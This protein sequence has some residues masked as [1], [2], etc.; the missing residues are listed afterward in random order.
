MEQ[1]LP[2]YGPSEPFRLAGLS[3]VTAACT[4]PHSAAPDCP[5]LDHL[6]PTV[7][8]LCYLC[9]FLVL[10]F[11]HSGRLAPS[12]LGLQY[13]MAIG[14]YSAVPPP[15]EIAQAQPLAAP[16]TTTTTAAATATAQDDSAPS[17]PHHGHTASGTIDIE[18][19]TLSALQSLSVSP[20]AT[21]TG[22][23]PLS[24]PL[25]EHS[26]L[27]QHST[28]RVTIALNEGDLGAITPPRRPPSRRD[29]MKRRE[30]LLKGKEGSR[31][32]RRW[33]MGPS[34]PSV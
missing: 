8:F 9:C 28:S 31:Q 26:R 24:I 23:Q 4:A 14:K 22:G 16:P 1:S 15:P 2:L 27:A 10:S 33:D 19:W 12:G 6:A 25:D 20:A 34:L 32:R 21:G 3:A 17:Q 5:Y 30:A 18:A 11:V 13:A 29:S 7:H